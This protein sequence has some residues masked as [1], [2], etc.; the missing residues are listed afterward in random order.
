LETVHQ[1]PQT[2]VTDIY[3]ITNQQLQLEEQE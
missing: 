3:Q 1:D 2:S